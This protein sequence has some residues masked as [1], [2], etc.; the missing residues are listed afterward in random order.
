MVRWHEFKLIVNSVLRVMYL[1]WYLIPF[2]P[3]SN[4]TDLTGFLVCVC[5]CVCL[6]HVCCQFELLHLLL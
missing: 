5:V 2:I 4:N 6:W 3:Q 1:T